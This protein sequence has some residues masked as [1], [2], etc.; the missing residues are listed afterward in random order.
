MLRDRKLESDEEIALVQISSCSRKFEQVQSSLVVV[1]KSLV[2]NRHKL[3]TASRSRSEEVL[4]L[5]H[6]GCRKKDK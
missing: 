2:V 5:G 6:G 4:Q 1:G 3:T